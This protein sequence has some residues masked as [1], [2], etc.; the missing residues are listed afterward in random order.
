MPLVDQVQS[1]TLLSLEESDGQTSMTFRRLIQS[2]DDQDFHI[3]VR[4]HI[5]TSPDKRK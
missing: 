3:T 1:Y 4:S 5:D 2:C